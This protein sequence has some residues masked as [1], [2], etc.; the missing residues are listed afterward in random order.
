MKSYTCTQ[1]LGDPV[2]L[3]IVDIRGSLFETDNFRVFAVASPVIGDG[4]R[5]LCT[6]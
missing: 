2:A 6:C 5:I 4:N 3:S 1:G